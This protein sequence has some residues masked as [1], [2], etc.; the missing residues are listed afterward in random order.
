MSI[1]ADHDLRCRA[2]GPSKRKRVAWPEGNAV[3][4][5]GVSE[6]LLQDYQGRGIFTKL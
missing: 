4:S 3:R 2:T 1:T 6:G 5:Y